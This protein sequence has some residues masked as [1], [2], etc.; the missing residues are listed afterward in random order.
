MEKNKNMKRN[1][2]K[3]IVKNYILNILYQA[4][5]LIIPLILTPYVSRVLLSDGIGKY[6]YASSIIYYFTVFGA[7]GTT[8]YGQ[9]EIAKRINLI[10]DRSKLF[11]E[12]FIV[13]LF[14]CLISFA[15]NIFFCL[16]G[17]YGKYTYLLCILSINIISVALDIT[18]LF[19]GMEKFATIVSRNVLVKIIGVILVFLFVKTPNDVWKYTLINSMI[20]FFSALS[21]WVYLP[22]ALCKVR[23]SSL[24]PFSHIKPILIL[25][26]PTIAISIYTMLDKTLI[27]LILHSDSQ[28]GY[29][30]QAEKI[31]KMCVTV[32]TCLSTVM[33][34][35]NSIEFSEG[36]EE[37]I[38]S[39]IY[40]ATKIVWLLAVPMTF[41]LMAISNSMNYWFFGPGYEPVAKLMIAFSPIVI[42]LG[43][44]NITGVQY[45]IATGHDKTFTKSVVIGAIA[46]L[47]I[48]LV[49]IKTIGTIGAVLASV[50][51]ETLIL[52]IQ[53]MYLRKEFNIYQFFGT[54]WKNI[55]GSLMMF[56]ILSIISKTLQSS[57][58][59]TLILIVTGIIVYILSL[60]ILRDEF[61]CEF[62]RNGFSEIKR[63]L[64]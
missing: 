34:S 39:N 60:I 33:I 5:T 56:A 23:F 53:L 13:R 12:L 43:L 54:G 16:F 35:R 61:A 10:Y 41:G 24:K 48:N 49:L 19:Q 55:I 3:I 2:K 17:I 15:I 25:F 62:L 11:W 46:N 30:E 44:N 57:I 37:H 52:I 20:T 21:L 36:N 8:M 27:G 26:L 64:R 31:V 32:I 47:I 9:R 4:F 14:S 50:F 29:Y 18:F 42:V 7:L 40:F 22:Q 1:E 6:S 59:S 58:T 45:L 28:N 63:K 51:A 38:K